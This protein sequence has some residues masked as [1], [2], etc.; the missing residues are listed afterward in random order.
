ME[1]VRV[2]SGK[3]EVTLVKS[4]RLV[5]LKT[6]DLGELT[7]KNFVEEPIHNNLGGFRVV[8]LDRQSRDLDSR[9]DEVRSQEEVEVGTHVYYIE[10]S[11]RPLVPTGEI[12]IS[13]Q[14]GTAEQEQDIVLQEFKLEL[15]DR[16]SA[17]KV[18]AR[19]TAESR[20]PIKVAAALQSSSLVRIAEPDLDSLVDEYAFTAPSDD[21][22]DHQWHLKN[23]GVVVDANWRMRKGADAKVVDAWQRMGSAGSQDITIAVIDNGFDLTHPDLQSKV[24][25]PW[26]LWNNSSRIEQG[27]PRYTHGTPCASVALASSNG[28]GIVGAAPKARFMPISGTSFSLRAT[29]NM[30]EHAV[31]NG[32]DVIS[33]S[34]GTTDPAF[35]LSP[36]KEE[37]LA[38]AARE[39]RNGK[40]C[41]ICFAAGNENLDYINYYASHPDVIAVAASTSLDEHASYSNRGKEVSVCAPSNGDWPIIAARAWWDDGISWETGEFRFWRDGKARGQNYKHFGGTSSAAPLVAGIC[42][43]MLSENPDLTAAQVKDILQRTADKVGSPSEYDSNGHSR[44]YGYGRVNALR[45]VAEAIA[46]GME[47]KSSS[48]K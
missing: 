20:N 6:K 16:R 23:T 31:R 27:D 41:V 24:V 30:F 18:I 47:N 9:L 10:G 22:V 43:L 32:A 7:R 33:C 36:T 8:A 3:G 25:K 37:T 48:P 28:R 34:W 11:N 38:R 19:V 45:A 29:E 39:G 14:E 15:V 1:K 13:F 46:Y 26:D 5:G 44:K 42:A 21:L 12:Y 2:N 4:R 17:E 35:S 40:G